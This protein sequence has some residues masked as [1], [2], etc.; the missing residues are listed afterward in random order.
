[1]EPALATKEEVAGST[2]KVFTTISP[3][4]VRTIEAVFDPN[5]RGKTGCLRGKDGTIHGVTEVPSLFFTNGLMEWYIN[6]IHIFL[7]CHFHYTLMKDPVAVEKKKMALK[8]LVEVAK[9]ENKTLTI[10]GDFNK[11]DFHA[12]FKELGLKSLI[13]VEITGEDAQ[14]HIIGVFTTN[15][16]AKMVRN[17]PSMQVPECWKKEAAMKAKELIEKV[18]MGDADKT[19]AKKIL[20]NFLKEKVNAA[21]YSILD[22][23]PPFTWEEYGETYQFTALLG[24]NNWRFAL[25]P[26]YGF[27]L[28]TI[29]DAI[30][31]FDRDEVKVMLTN[32]IWTDLF[33]LEPPQDAPSHFKC[34]KPGDVHASVHE[35]VVC[36]FFMEKLQVLMPE[37]LLV[38]SPEI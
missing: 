8:A 30:P 37:H 2:N 22:H 3:K 38:S 18:R 36:K 32:V 20:I 17:E 6:F 1:M 7:V 35:K 11:E 13:P 31:D 29:K 14:G 16:H 10:A 25:F 33:N 24:V 23:I 21:N 34:A 5:T 27:L 26:L 28:G 12:F 9:Q 15:P 4:L 19:T